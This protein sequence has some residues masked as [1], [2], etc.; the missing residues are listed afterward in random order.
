MFV[1]KLHPNHNVLLNLTKLQLYEEGP[2]CLLQKRYNGHFILTFTYNCLLQF[3][4]LVVGFYCGIIL[5]L[6]VC[7]S[8]LLLFCKVQLRA[9]KILIVMKSC[10]NFSSTRNLFSAGHVGVKNASGDRRSESRRK[11]NANVFQSRRWILQRCVL[12]KALRV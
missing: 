9:A 7:P 2:V 1:T 8:T 4:C 10:T 11:R 3:D 6:P 12:Q 5:V